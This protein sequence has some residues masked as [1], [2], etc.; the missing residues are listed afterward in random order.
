MP[1]FELTDEEIRAPHRVPALGRPQR[2]AE[3]AAE[4]RGLRGKDD[5]VPV[6]EGRARLLLRRDGASSPSRFSAGCSPAGSTSRRT[7][8]RETL[9]FN[10]VR[11]IHTNALIVWL[12]LGFFGGTY[13]LLPEEAERELFSTKLAY[14]QLAHPRRRHAGRRRRLPL[15][16]PRRARVP[17]A[18]A[19]GQVRHPRRR[20]DLPRQRLADVARRAQ[21]RDHQHPAARPLASVAPLDLRLHQPGE[22]RARQD[23]LVVRRPPLGRGDLGARHGRDPRLPDAEADRRRPRG[24]REV[25]LRHRLD[26]ALLRHPRHRPPLS[27]DRHP[28]L[29]AVG[30]LDLLDSS[31]RRRSSR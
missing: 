4:R 22:P 9:P 26:R 29:L 27:L 17:R 16:D 2:H 14:I 1:H 18:A 11:M 28:R 7:R 30:R 20:G 25:A 31:R 6:P 12:L 13:Y 24:H 19:L 23:V 21:D 3:L 5:E 15:R 10:I 8:C